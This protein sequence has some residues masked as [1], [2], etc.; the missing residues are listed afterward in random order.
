MGTPEYGTAT[1]QDGENNVAVEL[2]IVKRKQTDPDVLE[3]LD[4]TTSTVELLADTGDVFA[5]SILDAVNGLA[6][7]VWTAGDLIP[8]AHDVQVLV[9]YPN[10]NIFKGPRFVLDVEPSVA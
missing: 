7:Y 10:G 8:G 4:L 6:A 1:I 9:T 5:C 2:E 3:P